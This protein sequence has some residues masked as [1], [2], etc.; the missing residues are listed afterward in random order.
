MCVAVQVMSSLISHGQ[1][2]TM[3]QQQLRLLLQYAE[4]D[5][6]DYTRHGVAFTLLK[7]VLRRRLKC[8]Q[9]SELISR[10]QQLSVTSTEPTVR[11][12]CRS[13][14]TTYLLD[15]PV[16]EQV[17]THLAFY[18]KQL[19]YEEVDGRL[20]ALDMFL[21]ICRHFPPPVLAFHAGLIFV[22][23]SQ[24]LA[25]DDSQEVKR[26]VRTVIAALL[27]QLHKPNRKQLFDIAL[28]WLTDNKVRCAL[29]AH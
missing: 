28:S 10:C 25:N 23:L 24:R 15:Y 29:L 9:L 27:T 14:V 17:D 7:A 1:F 26:R 22:P 8:P 13:V 20:S 16:H 5:L 6:D 12:Q 18:V 19:T 21:N 2:D 4:H 11:Q 3:S